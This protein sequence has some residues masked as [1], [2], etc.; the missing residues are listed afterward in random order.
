M[1]IDAEN[2]IW[3]EHRDRELGYARLLADQIARAGLGSTNI[4]SLAFHLPLGTLLSPR[5]VFVP[6]LRSANDEGL[7]I[8]R[9]APRQ[10]FNI[11]YEQLLGNFNR[12]AKRPRCSGVMQ[13]YWYD[14]FRE[15]LDDWEVPDS[16]R[17]RLPPPESLL[18][19]ERAREQEWHRTRDGRLH[20]RIV[21]L[22]ENYA[23]AFADSETL[24]KKA[25]VGFRMEQIERLRD[26]SRDSLQAFA[27]ELLAYSAAH[28]DVVFVLRPHPSVSIETY[29]SEL[30]RHGEIPI[31]LIL[32]KAGSAWDWVGCSDAVISGWSTVTYSASQ[33]GVPTALHLP[34][35]LI[36]ELDVPWVAAMPRF[37]CFQDAVDHLLSGCW[38][39]DASTEDC[40]NF[41]ELLAAMR[42]G[43]H[44]I[45]CPPGLGRI[46]VFLRSLISSAVRYLGL[47]WRPANVRVLSV[48]HADH[49][50]P[51]HISTSTAS[52]CHATSS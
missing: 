45:D 16:L 17:V 47:I 52:Y 46:R 26:Y 9:R 43:S 42:S 7:S 36:P 49:F 20:D 24:R 1:Q 27:R 48:Y 21:F 33:L 4:L 37:R 11:N 22:P 18:L 25:G 12:E 2:L 31:N 6:Y 35:P 10:V 3:V 15:I 51:I 41:E 19:T 30:R 29:E 13:L 5:R 50:K 38:Q 39:A 28:P 34:L 23:W 32:S 14:A 8:L 44:T 40:S